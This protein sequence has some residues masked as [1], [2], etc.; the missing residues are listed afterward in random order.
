MAEKQE[1]EICEEEEEAGT[2]WISP[3]HLFQVDFLLTLANSSEV[4]SGYPFRPKYPRNIE[5]G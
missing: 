4:S 3:E 1:K 5:S 2:V